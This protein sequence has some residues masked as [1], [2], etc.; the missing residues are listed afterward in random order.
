L[1]LLVHYIGG[2]A[3][4]LLAL[5]LFSTFNFFVRMGGAYVAAYRLTFYIPDIGIII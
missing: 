1:A 3:K 5:L 2:K 4:P